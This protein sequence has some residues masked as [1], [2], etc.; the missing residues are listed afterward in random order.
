M[1]GPR[2]C[3]QGRRTAWQASSTPGKRTSVLGAAAD[4]AARPR[5][6]PPPADRWRA[7]SCPYD[8]RCTYAHG[9]HELRYVP[10]EIVAQLE[11]QQ[12]MQEAAGG[13]RAGGGD[14]Q[15]APPR[16]DAGGGGANG[17]PGGHQTYYKTRLCIKYMQQGS[18]HKARVCW[19]GGQKCPGAWLAPSPGA[20]RAAVLCDA[21]AAA[22]ARLSDVRLL[23]PAWLPQGQACT[24]A[25]GYED[26]RQ[27]GT[28]LSPRMPQVRAGRSARGLPRR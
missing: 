23:A 25:H 20:A 4:A 17:G 21:G 24:F 10:P 22:A 11:A 18:C 3:L 8:S 26:L 28:A 16:G 19:R 7:G 27:P 9:E 1:R 6:R 12:R 14:A 13:G 2:G 5:R 15:P